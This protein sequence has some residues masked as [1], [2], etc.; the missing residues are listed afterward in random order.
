MGKISNVITMMQLLNTGRKYSVDELASKLE[1]S[2]RMVRVYKD[3]LEKAGIYV[4]TLRGPYGGYVLNRS[5]R[6]PNRKFNLEDVK[7][8]MKIEQQTND[9][10]LKDELKV[11]L[12]KVRGIYQGSK[13]EKRELD[14]EKETLTKYNLFNKAIKQK[15]KVKILYYSYNTGENERIIHPYDM[16]LYNNGWGVASYCETK[17]D[18]RHFELNRTRKY[19]L[20]DEFYE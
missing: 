12:D 6:I 19:E 4:D 1:V 15:R 18:I 16:F 8:L 20:L 10:E 5:I 3:E 2:N 13:E 17:K 9:N 7:L 14:L 11:L